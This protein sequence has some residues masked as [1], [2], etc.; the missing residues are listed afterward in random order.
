MA[1]LT[2]SSNGERH[3]PF[4][5]MIFLALAAIAAVWLFSMQHAVERH[6]EKAVQVE[7]CF[8]NGSVLQKWQ[9][10]DGRFMYACDIPDQCIG[11]VVTEDGP[12]GEE[13]VTCFKN[14]NKKL[15]NLENYFRNHLAKQIW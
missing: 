14:K 12:D 5:L 13:I 3:S 9:K 4:G 1:A 10:P 11:I 7:G 8:N 6:G 15:E 2:R